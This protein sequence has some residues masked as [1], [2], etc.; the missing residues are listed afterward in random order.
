MHAL[1]RAAYAGAG[2]GPAAAVAD[3]L[4]DFA[5][6]IFDGSFLA[7]QN[8]PALVHGELMARMA[9]ALVALGDEIVRRS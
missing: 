8:E 6:G 9:D 1:L 3:E 7:V 2:D 5:V 4:A